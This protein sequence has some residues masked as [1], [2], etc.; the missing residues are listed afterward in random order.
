MITNKPYYEDEY[1]KLYHA[2]CYDIISQMRDK[3][4]DIVLSDP[5][6]GMRYKSNNYVDG[7]PWGEIKNDDHFPIEIMS[8]LFR[9]SRNAVILFCRWNNLVELNPQPKSL[10]VWDK[11][12]GS[13]GDLEHEYSRQYETAA[14]WAMENHSWRN[15]RPHDIIKVNKVHDLKHPTEKPQLLLQKIIEQNSGSSVFDPFCGSGSTLGAAKKLRLKSIGVEM[16]ERYCEVAANRLRDIK[17]D[18][19]WI[20]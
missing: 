11:G 2:N 10:I 12:G 14:F 20:E 17:I 9:L 13:M 15:G 18:D 1:T 8:D 19:D 7:N 6:F 3:C 4:L 5:P 16:E